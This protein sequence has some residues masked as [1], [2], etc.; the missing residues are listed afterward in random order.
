M[1]KMFRGVQRHAW[2]IAVAEVPF[3]LK[4]F[5]DVEGAYGPGGPRMQER[6]SIAFRVS[7]PGTC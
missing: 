6:S 4:P 1:P 3:D 7:P 2:K 5:K